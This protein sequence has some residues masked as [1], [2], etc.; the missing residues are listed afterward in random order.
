MAK[1][2]AI[3][4]HEMIRAD[5]TTLYRRFVGWTLEPG[6]RCELPEAQR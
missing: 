1:L 5:P 3:T 2:M 6:Q 4:Q